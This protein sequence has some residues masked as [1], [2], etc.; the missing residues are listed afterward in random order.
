[1]APALA[2]RHSKMCPIV[3]LEGMQCGLTTKSGMIPSM[4]K[5]KFSGLSVMPQVPFCPCLEAN[6]SPICGILML[7]ILTLTN[8][9]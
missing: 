3:I 4:V 5:G 7:L 8:F 1:M 6:L 9:L 2:T